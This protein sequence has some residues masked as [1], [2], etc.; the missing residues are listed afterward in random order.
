MKL[1]LLAAAALIAAPA[2]AQDAAQ[3][4]APATSAGS[5]PGGYG[6]TGSALSGPVQPGATVVFRQAP[7]PDQAYPAPAP[8]AKYPPCK[9]GQTDHCMQR[10]GH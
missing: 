2:M 10:G 3:Q 9:R 4:A 1:I 5:S 6:P 8:L 7:S